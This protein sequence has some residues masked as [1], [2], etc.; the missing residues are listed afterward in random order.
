MEDFQSYLPLFD[1]PCFFL[2]TE[3]EVFLGHKSSNHNV[4]GALTKMVQERMILQA[5]NKV[6]T[7]IYYM[8]HFGMEVLGHRAIPDYD[9][10]QDTYI[11]SIT[12]CSENGHRVI[13]SRQ[14][15]PTNKRQEQSAKKK[16][17]GHSISK[18]G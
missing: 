18:E 2:Q 14:R 5:N 9:T 12:I 13:N 6:G 16:D 7:A 1:L 8:G 4:E 10:R 17:Y 15:A 3:L 11:E